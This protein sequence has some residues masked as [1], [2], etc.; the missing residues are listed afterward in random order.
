MPEPDN[1]HPGD[2]S[3]PEASV[4]AEQRAG[5]LPLHGFSVEEDATAVFDRFRR[6]IA[7]RHRT[8]VLQA[9]KRWSEA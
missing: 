4:A 8:S 9:K 2:R 1:G 7:E 6:A 3:R 5:E